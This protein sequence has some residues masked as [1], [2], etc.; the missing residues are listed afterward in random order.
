MKT[1]ILRAL[2]QIEREKGIGKEALSEALQ[3]AMLSAYRKKFGGNQNIKIEIDWHTGNIHIYAI[4]E[5]VENVSD[6]RVEISLEDARKLGYNVI[7]GD[8]IDIEVT[9]KDFGRIAAQTARQVIVQKLQEA[10]KESIYEEFVNLKGEVVSGRIHR[11]ENRNIIV[12]IGRA[13]AVLPPREQI[14]TEVYKVG[15]YFKFYVVD[16]RKTPRGPKIIVS[17]THPGLVRGLFEMEVP[18]I[19]DGIVE[20]RGVAREPGFRT[21]VSVV[22]LNR[23]VEP[24][25]ACIGNK[26]SRITNVIN[27]LRGE[28]IDVIMWSEDPGEYV[29]NALSPAK[30]E[31]VKVIED[32]HTVMVYVDKSQISL[33]IGKDGQNA[34]LAARLTGWKVDIKPH[35]TEE[36]NPDEG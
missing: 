25:G 32:E 9:P 4:K 3:T 35:E 19:Q 10:E 7:V 27:E 20:I 28:K 23:D 21:K 13:E 34:R 33:A 1:N 8:T 12:L 17:R 11:F 36:N 31:K 6:P 2:R 18:E 22:S 24:I 5:V 15:E 30:V 14:L 16:V 29:A 26:G